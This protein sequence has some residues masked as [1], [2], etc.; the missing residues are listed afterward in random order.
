M[1]ARI[2]AF[3]IHL[4]SSIAL[5]SLFFALLF[6]AWYPGFFFEMEGVWAVAKMVI[7][8]DIVVGPFLT[9][10]VYDLRKGIAV[11]RRDVAVIIVVQLIAL[12]WGVRASYLGQPDYLAF[13]SGQF[14]TVS[15]S[16]VVGD[17]SDPQFAISSWDKPVNVYVRPIADGQER[18]QQIWDFL[19]GRAPDTQYQF[20]RYLPYRDYREAIVAEGKSVTA[21]IAGDAKRQALFDAFLTRHGGS[22]NDYLLYTVFAHEHEGTLVLSRAGAEP[23]GFIEMI[24]N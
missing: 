17:N 9:L 23:V 18:T 6:G 4:S 10:V 5:I 8:V 14:Y 1:P 24:I 16:E 7:L 3:L 2:K 13:A 15:R 22:E 20:D 11:V 19:E 21:A 12:G